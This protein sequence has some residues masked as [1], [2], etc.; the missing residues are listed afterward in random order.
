MIDPVE[1][2]D[3]LGDVRPEKHGGQSRQ[4]SDRTH[5]DICS[6]WRSRKRGVGMEVTMKVR[7]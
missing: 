2:T 5:L 3:I 6:G 1:A 7:E 4:G